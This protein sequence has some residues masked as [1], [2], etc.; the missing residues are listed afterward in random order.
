MS[1]HPSPSKDERDSKRP[2]HDLLYDC[3]AETFMGP[4]GT[5]VYRR[6]NAGLGIIEKTARWSLP[7]RDST[8]SFSPPPLVRPMP[9]I[10]FLPALLALRLL[11]CALSVIALLF[12]NPPV[13]PIAIVCF[14]QTKRRKLRAIRTRGL[15][16]HQICMAQAER[17][18]EE[19]F[20]QQQTNTWW[21]WL[22]QPFRHFLCLR[23][24]RLEPAIDERDRERHQNQQQRN[25]RPSVEP[26]ADES[27]RG[28]PLEHSSAK[29]RN[30]HERDADGQS[31]ALPGAVVQNQYD[32][33]NDIILHLSD[34]SSSD[35]D[36]YSSASENSKSET[37][38]NAEKNK[39]KKIKK[40]INGHATS[41]GTNPQPEVVKP[42]KSSLNVVESNADPKEKPSAENGNK[43]VEQNGLST[44]PV[45]ENGN[46]PAEKESKEEKLSESPQKAKDAAEG[47]SNEN[48]P[49]N[50]SSPDKEQPPKDDDSK[51]DNQDS[52]G[53]Q[54]PDSMKGGKANSQQKKKQQQQ[55]QKQ[56]TAA[57]GGRKH[58]KSPH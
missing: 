41:D 17:E 10:L 24:V 31:S 53:K 3:A 34:P 36:S 38:I 12:G 39:P 42:Q 23:N 32:S 20:G 49:N 46:V 22:T 50:Q 13:E 58:K 21:K 44:E 6:L 27:L 54:S 37:V 14:L 2:F 57:N 15:K 30:A 51:D 11:R 33:A 1:G 29:K 55:Q 7:R 16:L 47:D 26:T 25:Q 40:D 48:K 43:E 56:H 19:N 4:V 35:Y 45:A 18:A 52:S 5:V 8:K 28:Q 9:W